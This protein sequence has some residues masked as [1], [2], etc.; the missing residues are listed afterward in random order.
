MLGMH[1]TY[2]A[3]LAMYD[4]DVMIAIGVRAS[5][6]GSPARSDEFSPNSKKIHIDIDPSSINKNVHGRPADRRRR[7]PGSGRAVDQRCWETDERTLDAEG[8]QGLVGTRS[9]AGAPATAS[10]TART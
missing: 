7:R 6:T 1:G 3:N 4:C 5:T 8:A 2:E 10:S 9:T